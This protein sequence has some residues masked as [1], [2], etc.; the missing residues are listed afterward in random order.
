MSLMMGSSAP[1]YLASWLMSGYGGMSEGVDCIVG[2]LSNEIRFAIVMIRVS[3]NM[4]CEMMSAVLSPSSYIDF[5]GRL[6][7]LINFYA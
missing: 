7:I 5:P 6:I 3:C 4:C 2:R 1:S